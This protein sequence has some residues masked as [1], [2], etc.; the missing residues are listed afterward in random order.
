[1]FLWPSAFI[2]IVLSIF[3]LTWLF[4]ISPFDV[5]SVAIFKL[6]W[7]WRYI[8]CGIN[9]LMFQLKIIAKKD[10]SGLGY[11][12]GHRMQGQRKAQVTYNWPEA[13]IRRGFAVLKNSLLKHSSKLL[14][15]ISYPQNIQ[16]S[17]TLNYH[18]I[19][20]YCWCHN[21]KCNCVVKQAWF[22]LLRRNSQTEGFLA[23]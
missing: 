19:L 22:P 2:H 18:Y 8:K 21:F 16:C 23:N 14:K 6:M 11:L 13:W 20:C 10:V 3:W 15:P 4:G 5:Y 17:C 1:M 7:W 12:I 9:P